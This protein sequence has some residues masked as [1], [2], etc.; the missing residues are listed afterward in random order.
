MT[1]A[2]DIRGF[3]AHVYFDEVTRRT[4][5]R[6]RDELARQLGVEVGAMHE[7]PVGPHAKAM[8]EVAIT[9]EQFG[10]VVPWLML[11]RSGLSVLVHPTTDDEVADHETRPLWMGE[12]LAIDVEL[13]R[14]HVGG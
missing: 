8:F 5:E 12:V 14:R 4:A 2:A 6:M 10:A 9:P 7:R 3:H 11:N 1:Q 13:V